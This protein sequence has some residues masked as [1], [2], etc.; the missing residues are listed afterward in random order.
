MC[1]RMA[2]ITPIKIIS[3]LPYFFYIKFICEKNFLVECHFFF[4]IFIIKYACIKSEKCQMRLL[5]CVLQVT[6]GSRKEGTYLILDKSLI[7]FNAKFFVC[8][9]WCRF[10][11]NSNS[12]VRLR[13]FLKITLQY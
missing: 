11:L 6:Y 13:T 12:F 10:D 4:C 8:A 7:Q 9:L 5:S 3:F 1:V 2:F